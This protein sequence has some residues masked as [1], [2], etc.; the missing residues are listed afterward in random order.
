MILPD[1]WISKSELELMQ[2]LT[3][4]F[5]FDQNQNKGLLKSSLIPASMQIFFYKILLTSYLFFFWKI[6]AKI[7]NHI[8]TSLP[9]FS[10]VMTRL[11]SL[12]FHLWDVTRWPMVWSICHMGHCTVTRLHSLSMPSSPHNTENLLPKTALITNFYLRNSMMH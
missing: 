3:H 9:L 7:S 12:N 6:T 2:N 8:P 5:K 10:Y 1:H 4:Y 11:F